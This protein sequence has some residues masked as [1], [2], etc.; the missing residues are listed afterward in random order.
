VPFKPHNYFSSNLFQTALQDQMVSSFNEHDTNDKLG[1]KS[2]TIK[3]L[4]Y[5]QHDPHYVADQQIHLSTSQKQELA[6]LLM[7]VPK[8]FSRKLGCFPHKKVHLELQPNAKPFRCRPYPVPKHHEQVFKDKLQHLCDIGVLERC[9]P[10]EWLSPSFI[11]A[12]K[13]G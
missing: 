3:R 8:L 9:G 13:D 6:Q 5:K 12:K 2:K 10:S 11:I 7:Q 4:L 1:Y